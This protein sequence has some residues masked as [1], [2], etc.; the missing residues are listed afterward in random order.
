[1]QKPA[2]SSRSG[3]NFSSRSLAIGDNG[4]GSGQGVARSG[5][6]SHRPER[7]GEAAA[8]V[9]EHST[10]A[11]PT[12][13][14]CFQAGRERRTGLCIRTLPNAPLTA[15]QST[16]RCERMKHVRIPGVNL[17]TS[18]WSAGRPTVLSRS[19]F[20]VL[21]LAL[22]SLPTPA[23]AHHSY[24]MFDMSRSAVVQ[25]TVAKVEWIN[26]HVF[27]WVYVRKPGKPHEFDL[28]AFENGPVNMMVRFGW[29]KDSLKAGDKLSVLY[30]PM[31]DAT[32]RG[33]YFVKS[34]RTDGIELTGDSHA[35]GVMKELARGIPLERPKP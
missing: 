28:Y 22:A 29:T 32:Q 34:V 21:L 17:I 30:F 16:S 15:E 35:P 19:S 26:P 14:A 25:G 11:T 33:G 10:L 9:N 4:S 24:A 1:M 23:H 2:G 13:A 12:S 3:S 7:S 18:R 5:T 6:G 31:R 20:A 8:A 27:V